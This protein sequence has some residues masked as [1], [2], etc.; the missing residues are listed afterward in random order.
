MSVSHRR[1]SDDDSDLLDEDDHEMVET[2]VFEPAEAS[3]GS[4]KKKTTLKSAQF[5]AGS[6]PE[7]DDENYDDVD[8]MSSG[9]ES[10]FNPETEAALLKD[11]ERD[12]IQEFKQMEKRT[13]HRKDLKQVW[14]MIASPDFSAVEPNIDFGKDPFLGLSPQDPA[15]TAMWNEAEGDLAAW[16][17]P[18]P[19]SGPAPRSAPEEDLDLDAVPSNT[20][21]RLSKKVRFRRLSSVTSDE[22]PSEAFPDLMDSVTPVARYPP[23]SLFST[24]AAEAIE[25]DSSDES[26]DE[27]DYSMGFANTLQTEES[28]IENSDGESESSDSECMHDPCESALAIETLLTFRKPM[29]TPRMKNWTET[30]KRERSTIA[31]FRSIFAR[32]ERS[33]T[34]IAS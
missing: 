12:L 30:K 5:S 13:D 14:N 26:G 15:H 28:F 32:L 24:T 25:F 22:D 2:D 18:A 7:N 29:E 19:L 11:S 17:L 34:A 31:P 33:S 16:R 21:P 4:R 3:N 10:D 1:Q 27:Y 23:T 9:D 20:S 6:D 8:A